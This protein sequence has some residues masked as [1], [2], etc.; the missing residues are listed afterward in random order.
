VWDGSELP[1][2]D[3]TTWCVEEEVRRSPSEEVYRHKIRCTVSWSI[4]TNTKILSVIA[5][6]LHDTFTFKRKLFHAGNTFYSAA[7]DTVLSRTA[8][9]LAALCDASVPT[10]ERIVQQEE[11][12]NL[13]LSWR[14][15]RIIVGGDTVV[16]IV[17]GWVTEESRF[18]IRHCR[19]FSSKAPF[20]LC[21]S[22]VNG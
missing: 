9:K 21:G 10:S 15:S 6:Q 11:N 14:P 12:K 7:Q 8:V 16:D 17:T 13:A 18:D 2:T 20:Q 22:A 19:R 3:E 1:R 5:L 4:I